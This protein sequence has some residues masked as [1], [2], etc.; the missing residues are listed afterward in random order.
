MIQKMKKRLTISS[1]DTIEIQRQLSEGKLK[2]RGR[3]LLQKRLL[4]TYFESYV[5]LDKKDATVI[6]SRDT[7]SD[8]AIDQLNNEVIDFIVREY[9]IPESKIITYFRTQFITAINNKTIEFPKSSIIQ[10]TIECGGEGENSEPAT[11]VVH[12]VDTQTPQSLF[13]ADKE[14]KEKMDNMFDLRD[15]ELQKVGRSVEL[16]ACWV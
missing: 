11:I 10:P 15:T 2:E 5:N 7:I 12:N 1:F 6:C 8:R 16:R 9:Q 14:L 3:E 4:M 13:Q